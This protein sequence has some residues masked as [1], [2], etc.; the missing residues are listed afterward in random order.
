MAGPLLLD[1]AMGTRLIARGLD[2]SGDDPCLWCLDRP[3]E[4]AEIHRLDVRAGADALTT[5]TFGAN[6][7]W[8]SR[9]GRADE[10]AEINRAAVAIAREAAGPDRL[11]LGCIG[12]SATFREG[13]GPGPLAEQAYALARAGVDALILETCLAS[14]PRLL[15]V[16]VFLHE[17]A[18]TPVILSVALVADDDPTP[19]PMLRDL[20]P[21]GLAAVGWNCIPPGRAVELPGRLRGPGRIPLVLQPSGP[22]VGSGPGVEPTPETIARLIGQGVRIFGG[23]CGT[24]ERDIAALRSVLGPSTLRAGSG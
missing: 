11:V 24:T 3:E 1:A 17:L 9:F 16:V 18:R 15:D 21:S 10:A 4:V 23:C 22:W 13:E 19:M 20:R 14:D 5:N 12:P 8:L 2:L 6:H 7:A